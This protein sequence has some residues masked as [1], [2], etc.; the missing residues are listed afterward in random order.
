MTLN[1]TIT[2]TPDGLTAELEAHCT[3]EPERALQM[4]L[5]NVIDAALREH[6]AAQGLQKNAPATLP[7]K[8]PAALGQPQ[9][10]R[11]N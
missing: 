8:N 6:A 4:R 10:R 1:L 9:H 7:A 3:G 5:L 11:N 2:L